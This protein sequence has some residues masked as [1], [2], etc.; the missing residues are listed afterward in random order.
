MAAKA[1]EKAKTQDKS[2]GG[3]T[4]LVQ[5]TGTGIV[6]QWKILLKMVPE[7]EIPQFVDPNHWLKYFPPIG[8]THLKNFGAG[9]DWRRGLP[10]PR[11]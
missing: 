5:K 9:V 11:G 3:K 2:K 10:F 7:E 6:R 8:V 4:K 1:A